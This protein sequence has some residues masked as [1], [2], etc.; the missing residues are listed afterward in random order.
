MLQESPILV[1]KRFDFAAFF[2]HQ[3]RATGVFEN[4]FGGRKHS[5]EATFDGE[6]CH[7][8]FLLHEDFLF[9]DGKTEQRVWRI[10][11][12]VGGRFESSCTQIVG[13]GTGHLTQ[14]GCRHSF[15]YRLPIG[16]RIV[17]FRIDES[18]YAFEP[19]K[20]LYQA[21][22][23]KWGILAGVIHMSFLKDTN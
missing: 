6:W 19:G 8:T 5:F 13:H 22:L 3:T 1:Q 12:D 16:R 4:R 17:T 14:D 7:D 2:E 20:L 21:T 9:C 11:F 18:Y 10:R 15:L 23:K